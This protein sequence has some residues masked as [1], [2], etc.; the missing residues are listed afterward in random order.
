MNTNELT[1]D[2]QNHL[3]AII[4][5]YGTGQHPYA[6]LGSLSYFEQTYIDECLDTAFGANKD[7]MRRGIINEIRGVTV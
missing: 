7:E 1:K 6:D 2:L 4:N 5:I 3:C